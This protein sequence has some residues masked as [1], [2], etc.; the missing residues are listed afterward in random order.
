MISTSGPNLS[1]LTARTTALEGRAT[2]SEANTVKL[3]GRAT[4]LEGR[5]AASESQTTERNS[6]IDARLDSTLA[7]IIEHDRALYWLKRNWPIVLSIVVLNATITI[8]LIHF[9][10]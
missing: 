4:A 10:R 6:A 2:A 8:L 7:Q 9:G 3:E 5:A 1:G